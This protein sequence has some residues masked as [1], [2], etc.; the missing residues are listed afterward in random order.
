MQAVAHARSIRV[1]RLSAGVAARLERLPDDAG[2]VHSVFARALNL[3]CADGR[4]L[5]LQGPGPLVAP[6][7]AALARLP[8]PGDVRRGVSVRRRGDCLTLAGACLRWR[9][10]TIVGTAMPESPVGPGPALSRLG[11]EP[12]PTTGRGLGSAIGRGARYRLAKGLS[13]R[14]PE[15]FIAGARGLLGLGEG[16]TPAGDDCLV[17]A[18]AVI[19]RFA[20]TWLRAHPEIPTC[21]G[22]AADGTT[23]VAREFIA[24]ALAGHF[25]ESLLDLLTADSA[26]ATRRATA[27]VLRIGATSGADTLVGVRLA[28]S[29]LGA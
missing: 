13:R 29:A 4:L 25:A 26:D 21:L 18:L 14:D 11:G 2:R 19:H 8:G 27:R 22:G 17:G 24:H 6:F 20:A 3:E 28:L 12:V 9:G 7:A 10:A 5:T 23:D 1:L 16:L 15:A